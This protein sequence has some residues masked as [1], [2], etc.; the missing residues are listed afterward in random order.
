MIARFLTAFALLLLGAQPA[1]AQSRAEIERTMMRATRFMVEEVSTN[2]GYVWSYLPDMSRRWGEIEAKPSMIWVQPPGTATM[3]HV[4]LDAYRATADD[5]YYRAAEQVGNALVWG[6]HPSGGWNYFIDFA[7]EAS[8]RH[9]YETIGRNAWRMEE[10]QHYGGNATFDDAGTSEAMQFL[11]R[12]YVEK[13]DP[14]YRPAVE[15][16][17]NFVLESQ[18]PI[19]GWPQRYPHSESYPEYAR[20]ITFNDDVAAE[21]IRFLIM[22]YQALGETRVMDSIVRGM[23][24]YLVTQLGAPQPGWALQYTLDLKPAGARSYEPDSLATHTTASNVQALMNFYRLTGETKFLARIPEAL[25]WLE[26]VR[27][28]AGQERGNRAYPTFI[29]LGTNR[30]IYVHRRGSNVVNGQYYW[31]FNPEAT[32]GHYNAFRA[33]DVAAL[34]REYERLRATAPEEVRRTSPLHATTQQPLP[35]FFVT[36]EDFGSDLNAGGGGDPRSLIRAL[37]T[38]GYWP[39]PLRATSNPYIGPGPATPPPGDFRTSHV[40]DASDTSPYNTDTPVTGISTATYIAN[41][42]RLIRA[43]EPAAAR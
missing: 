12:L 21:N 10:F 22:A 6:Q 29:E 19:G 37:N 28:P 2:G 33:I 24:V 8:T 17:L 35:R 7:G 40:G 39:T 32:L 16:A 34:R 18:Y 23:N 38:R 3:G 26:S 5:Y 25:D 27:V 36:G 20:L 9:W 4:F 30:P 31:D 11:L 14:R 41:M 13:R 42:A 43:I 15:R 1:L